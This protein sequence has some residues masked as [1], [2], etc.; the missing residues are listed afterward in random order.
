MLLFTPDS[1][2]CWCELSR[3]NIPS[4]DIL[5]FIPTVLLEHDKCA[6]VENEGNMKKHKCSDVFNS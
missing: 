3:I 2:G 5:R 4:A 1:R 6:D